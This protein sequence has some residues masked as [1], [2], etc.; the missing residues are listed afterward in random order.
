MSD[1]IGSKWVKCSKWKTRTVNGINLK[2]WKFK[3]TAYGSQVNG[4][5]PR[6]AHCIRHVLTTSLRPHKFRRIGQKDAKPM[7]TD[8]AGQVVIWRVLC[9]VVHAIWNFVPTISGPLL[10]PAQ[11]SPATSPLTEQSRSH[12]KWSEKKRNKRR[13]G[14]GDCSRS[15]KSA[16][17]LILIYQHI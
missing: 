5:W 10:V 15:E 8:L 16:G 17:D 7:D 12:E 11:Q 14:R 13:S 3:S 6:A 9:S 1:S 4:Q 2:T